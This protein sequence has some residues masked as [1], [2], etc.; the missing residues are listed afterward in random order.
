MESVDALQT[1]KKGDRLK[2]VV[3]AS[4]V[5]HFGRED[6]EKPKFANIIEATGVLEKLG[7]DPLIIADA[8]LRHEIDEKEKFLEFLENGKITQVPSGTTADHFI[9]K[10][11]E[12]LN[13]KI[14]S[15]DTFREYYDEFHDISGKRIPYT[16]KDGKISIGTPT[17]PK[18]IKN[19]LQR[20]CS[21][22]LGE[23]EK[24]GMEVYRSKK[25]KNLTGIAIAKEAIDRITKSREEGIEP[26]IEGLLMKIPLFDKVLDMVEDAERTSDFILFVLVNP[27][28]YKDVV[29]NAGNIAV[30]VGD[31]LKLDHAPLVA[32]RNDLFTRPGSFEL[33]IIYSDEV[34][35]EA[36][37]NV[38]ITIN[39]HDYAF[40]KKNSRNIASTIA[41]RSGTW[42]FP[43]VSV[44]PSILMEK[45]GHFDI[46]LEKGG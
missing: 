20:I 2:V 41:A 17:K 12:E 40:V 13:A 24:K 8:S 21:Q 16:I 31:R 32:V 36:P 10:T 14:L 44:K 15:N 33:N 29:K 6:N 23:L 30:T 26:K 25:S 42:R 34:I 27:K 19:I 35:E 39:D 45:P 18:K 3:D 43:I 11:A 28:D 4:N 46:V 7:Y 38:S 9:L 37:Y 22:I 1:T 5:A